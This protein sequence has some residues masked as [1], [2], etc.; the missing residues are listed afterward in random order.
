MELVRKRRESAGK[1]DGP[2]TEK[3]D[4]PLLVK[5]VDIDRNRILKVKSVLL[6]N[7][8]REVFSFLYQLFGKIRS[9][10]DPVKPAHKSSSHNDCAALS[11]SR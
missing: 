3:K 1:C 4:I 2:E 10:G 9:T 7:P 8:K 11:P 6:H 5:F